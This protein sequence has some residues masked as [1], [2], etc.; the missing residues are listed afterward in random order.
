MQILRI[1]SRLLLGLAGIA[2]C[3]SAWWIVYQDSMARVEDKSTGP[4]E[5]EIAVEVM[6]VRVDY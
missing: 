3:W 4:G 6:P 1:F 2:A 5:A